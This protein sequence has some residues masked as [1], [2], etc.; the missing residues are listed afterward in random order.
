MWQFTDA[1]RGRT[2]FYKDEFNQG[3]VSLKL[4]DVRLQDE[5][6]YLCMVEHQNIIQQ[7]SV[8]LK[9]ASF[10]NRPA[11]R[12][13]GYHANGIRLQCDSSSWYPAPALNWADENGKDM[14]GKATTKPAQSTGGLYSISSTIEVTSGSASA[15]KCLVN[16]NILKHSQESSLQIPDEFFPR[17]SKFFTVFILFLIVLLGLMAGAGYYQFRKWTDIKELHKRPTLKSK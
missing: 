5:G 8:K 15:F 3:N 1:Y 4:K 6:T 7:T 12:L 17:M 11:I 16:S 14:T 9:V 13:D 2:E 10:G